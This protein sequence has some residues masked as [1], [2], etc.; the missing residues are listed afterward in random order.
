MSADASGC[1]AAAPEIKYAGFWIRLLAGVIDLVITGLIFFSAVIIVP[2]L[3]GPLIGVPSG[4]AIVAGAAVTWLVIT[5]LY[6]AIMESSS[7]QA[8]VGKGMLDIVVTDAE[9]KR[10]SFRKASLRHLWKLASALP[11]LAGFVVAGFTARKQAVHD[12]IAGTLVV[13]KQ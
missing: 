5:W 4:A 9:G 13:T 1:P 7:K 6:W 12:L 2:I 8:T 3:L 10:M 11:A